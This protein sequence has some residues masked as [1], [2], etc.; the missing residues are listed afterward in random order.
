MKK[1]LLLLALLSLVL[2]CGCTQSEIACGVDAEHRAFLCWDVSIDS[3]ELALGE[4][5][6]LLNWVRALAEDMERKGCTVEHNALGATGQVVY[7]RAELTKQGADDVEAMALLR[8][9]LTDPELTPFTAV[10]AE[11]AGEELG[12]AFR[13]RL[14]LEPDRLLATAGIDDFPKRTRERV[15]AWIEGATLTLRMTLPAQTLPEGETAE[16]RDG[17]A[18]KAVT[19][20]LNG[21]TEQSLQTSVYLGGGDT[22]Q[23][24][25]RGTERSASSAEELERQMQREAAGLQKSAD[26]LNYCA[27]GL[28]VLAL[29]FFTWGTVRAAKRRRA[30]KLF[31]EEETAED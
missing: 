7:L 23:L 21:N 6:E 3:G 5:V 26:V 14:R 30:A 10:E 4:Q 13:L 17:L 11:A 24:W 9:M 22:A 18:E 29:P 16:L 19:I 15:E 31:I 8:G 20:P 2:L 28:G 25:W 12:E 1:C 27:V